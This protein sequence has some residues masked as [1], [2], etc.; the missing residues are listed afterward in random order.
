M[1][2]AAMVI[3]DAIGGIPAGDGGIVSIFDGVILEDPRGNPRLQFNW[4][5]R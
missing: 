2:V 4:M 1:T 3:V 5:T